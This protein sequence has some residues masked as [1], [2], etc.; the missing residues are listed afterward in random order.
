MPVEL[1]QKQRVQR[2]VTWQPYDRVP[3]Y[4]PVG[5]D[6]IAWASGRLTPWQEDERY[7]EVA[8]LV[9]EHCALEGRYRSA[10]GL[11]SRAHMLI[12]DEYIE[13]RPLETRGAHTFRTTIVHTPRGDLRTVS[14]TDRAIATTWMIEP[15]IKCA[16]D[17]EA[18]LSVPFEPNLPDP[19]PFLAERRAWGERGLIEL[20]VST[21][22]VCTSHIMPFAL[23]LEWTASNRP[24]I[25][26]MIATICERISVRLEHLLK[27][28]AIECIWLG[29]SEQATPPMMSHQF[30]RELVVRYDGRL[31][32][33]AKRY[34]ALV[35]IHCHGKVNDVLEL[36][37]DMGADMTD[38][39]EPTPDGDVDFADAR[40]RCRRRLVLMGNI[41]FRHIEFCERAQIDEMVRRAICDGGKTGVMLYPSAR[42]L[43]WMTDRCRDNCLQY[44]ES[45]LR[46]GEM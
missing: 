8:E 32:E 27:A 29:G 6:P 12:P 10:G 43:T 44:I 14:R 21:P 45:A 20:G 35:H 11:F 46:Y 39:V 30:Y 34:G 26:R 40:H 31:I 15:L 25:E 16:A 2:C 28:G 33:L 22:M 37:M 24:L 41:E 13:H 9:A 1:T 7:R 18:M 38:P 3:I 42:P 23:F 36:M 17:A 4:A 5:F 19:A